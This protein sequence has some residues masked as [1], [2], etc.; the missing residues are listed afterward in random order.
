[1]EVR[2]SGSEGS[3]RRE[4]RA[5]E[6]QIEESFG[7]AISTAKQQKSISLLKRAEASKAEYRRKKAVSKH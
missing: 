6:T 1:V 3:L 7:E 2:D 4:Q 5:D